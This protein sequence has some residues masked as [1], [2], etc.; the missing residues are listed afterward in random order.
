MYARRPGLSDREQDE[1]RIILEFFAAEFR[2]LSENFLLY[3]GG[4]L[5]ARFPK[6]F[7]QTRL[8]EFF[9]VARH[10][11]DSVGI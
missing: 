3:F 9:T 1:R 4:I 11:R 5:F 7:D 10:F 2:D 8:A 6:H